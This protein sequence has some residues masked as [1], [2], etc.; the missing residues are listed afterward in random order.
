MDREGKL[1]AKDQELQD[2]ERL[3]KMANEEREAAT[4]K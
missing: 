4:Q 1:K 3:V 2:K